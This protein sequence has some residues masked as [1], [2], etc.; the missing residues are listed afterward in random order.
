M[1]INLFSGD[2]H[3]LKLYHGSNV[4]V[5]KPEVRVV[6]YTKDFGYGF[7]CTND[8]RQA[9]TWAKRKARRYD[10]PV[11]SLYNVNPVKFSELSY[12]RFTMYDESWLDFIANCRAGVAHDY[13]IVEGPMAD[14][15]VWDYVDTYLSGNMSKEAFLALCKFKHPT[16]QVCFCTDIALDLLQFVEVCNEKL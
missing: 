1:R 8:L 10:V 9:F 3:A 12:L 16:H 11:V 13:D 7:Y 6:G 4:V 2:S 15:D 14:D 5:T